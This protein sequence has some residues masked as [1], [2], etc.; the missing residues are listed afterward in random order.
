MSLP[1]TLENQLLAKSKILM[2]THLK[3]IRTHFGWIKIFRKDNLLQKVENW[4]I[5]KN[6]KKS[7]S[8]EVK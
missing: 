3:F 5:L 8:K 1:I 2:D 7:K 6:K 4:L